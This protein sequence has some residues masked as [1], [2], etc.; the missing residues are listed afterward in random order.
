[1]HFSVLYDILWDFPNIN[2]CAGFSMSGFVYYFVQLLDFCKL[3]FHTKKTCA[4][5]LHSLAGG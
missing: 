3:V 4:N 2:I 5:R 1:M